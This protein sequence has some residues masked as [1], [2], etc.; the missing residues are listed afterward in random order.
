LEPIVTTHDPVPEQPPPDQPANLDPGSVAAV[1]VTGTPWPMGAE[2]VV[3][4]EIPPGSLLTLPEPLPA[5]DVLRVYH[6]AGG[7]AVTR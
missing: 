1:S 5:T 7:S 2:H 6:V 3:G 4:H